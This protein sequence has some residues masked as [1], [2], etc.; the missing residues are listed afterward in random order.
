MNTG[1]AVSRYLDKLHTITARHPQF[2]ASGTPGYAEAASWVQRTLESTGLKV[3]RQPFY[4]RYTHT[5]D[6]RLVSAS[7]PVKMEAATYS[8]S[9]P[10]GGI[11]RL[12]AVPPGPPAART[13]CDPALLDRAALAGRIALLDAADCG[14]DAQARNAAR[15]G[16][17][18]VLVASSDPEVP[19]FGGLRDLGT[20]VPVGGVSAS[21]ADRLVADAAAGRPVTMTVDTITEVR[22]TVNI[23]AE[24]P[25]G[26]PDTRIV[27]GAHLDSVPDSPGANDNGAAVAALLDTAVET[28]RQADPPRNKLVFA[29]WGAEEFDLVGSRK[30]VAE[31]S[32]G[33]VDMYVNLEMI[34]GS[35]YGSFFLNGQAPAA[36]P[37]SA[38]IA[39]N[40]EN[41]I[42]DL[43]GSPDPWPLDRRSDYGPFLDAGIPAGGIW[44]GSFE[45]KTAEQAQRWGGTA[46]A[47]FAPCY[48]K[49]CDIPSNVDREALLLHTKAFKRTIAKLSDAKMNSQ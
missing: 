8:P 33:A 5:R 27:S 40:L 20:S 14:L 21:T 43:G 31:Q 24:T 4:F 12:V 45:T 25:G 19:Y 41:A 32:P 30:Y 26:D 17:V 23:I 35:N 28:G 39:R 48:H 49:K 11:R 15:A 44:G 22:R 42:A 13:G 37:G 10:P 9:T 3:T 46:G 34:A 7:G 1:A 6:A 47:A 18:A 38:V 29:F 36:P 16:A 2:R